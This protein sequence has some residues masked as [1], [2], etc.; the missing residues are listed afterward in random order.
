MMNKQ[1]V[2]IQECANDR[3]NWRLVT[4]SEQFPLG[5]IEIIHFDMYGN[6]ANENASTYTFN[7]I[8]NVKNRP[9]LM[10]MIKEVVYPK[11]SY[12]DINDDYGNP[13]PKGDL[14]ACMAYNEHNESY[15]TVYYRQEE[16]VKEMEV[17]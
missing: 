2:S 3:S 9:E 1:L 15:V 11:L 12:M 13:Y 8:C 17:E 16:L 5:M 4:Y 14:R 10:K 7:W 6:V